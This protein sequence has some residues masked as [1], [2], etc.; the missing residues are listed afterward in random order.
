MCG[1]PV[2]GGRGL[3]VYGTLQLL[4]HTLSS[5]L[6]LIFWRSYPFRPTAN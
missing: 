4:L 5:G 1:G 2:A 3:H 6:P